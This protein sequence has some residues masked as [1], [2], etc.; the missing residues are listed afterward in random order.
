VVLDQSSKDPRRVRA[1]QAGMRAR[2]GEPRVLRIDDLQP[3]ER[4]L[5]L[6]LVEAVRSEKAAPVGETSGTADA[7]GRRHV[8]EP[9]AS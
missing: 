5:V 1:G 8:V 9:T 3:N 6:A 4:R 2:W 7:G